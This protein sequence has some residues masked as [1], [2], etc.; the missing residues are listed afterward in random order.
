MII[1]HIGH[2]EFLIETENGMRIVTDPYDGNCGY[3]D[4]RLKADAALVSHSHNDHNAVET[5]EGLRTVVDREGEY[6][7]AA[8]VKV[9]AV[10]GYHDDVQGRERGETLLFLLETEG[11]RLV[12]LGDLGCMPDRE[13]AELLKRPDILMIPVG[14]FYTIDGKTA[15]KTADMLGARTVLP[16]HYKTRYI[17]EWPISGPEDFLEGIPEKEIRR[18]ILF[19]ARIQKYKYCLVVEKVSSVDRRK[20]ISIGIAESFIIP[21][22]HNN[23]P[24]IKRNPVNTGP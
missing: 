24:V 11:L 14:G 5:L 8:G 9:T 7:L 1:Q 20:H 10:K 12:H 21:Y 23:S 16:M 22:R 17:A 4:R 15:R 2:A 13:Q 6:T 19:A 18:D 3:P